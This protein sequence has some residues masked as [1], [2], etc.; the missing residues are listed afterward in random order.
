M[1]KGICTAAESIQSWSKLCLEKALTYSQNDLDSLISCAKTIQE[2]PKRERRLVGAD[3]RNDMR[4]VS[5]EHAGDFAVFLRQS[6]DFPENFSIG[7]V[8]DAKD[9][10][11]EITLLRCNGQ[12][13]VFSGTFD[14]AH[15]HWGYHIHRASA[16]ML[17]AG[18]KAE[19][20]ADSTDKYA[21]YEE[22]VQYFVK[23]INLDPAE[24]SKY[25]PDRFSQGSLPF[26]TGDK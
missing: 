9:G 8:Y 20:R 6:E 3:W 10:T 14:P 2:P 11:G 13:G 25:F 1:N 5:A 22:A 24:A 4:L 26:G 19:K 12:H 16:D 23:L 15:P 17:N 21:S 18:L 7:L